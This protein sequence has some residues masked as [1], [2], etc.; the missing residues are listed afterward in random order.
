MRRNRT[1]S[2]PGMFE[3]PERNCQPGILKNTVVAGEEYSCSP[4][5]D[6]EQDEGDRRV[7]DMWGVAKTVMVVLEPEANPD[8]RFSG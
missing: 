6:K 4:D 1:C 3:L 7:Q 5:S 8:Q 2:M